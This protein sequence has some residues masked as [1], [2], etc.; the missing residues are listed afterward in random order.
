MI[1]AWNKKYYQP[2]DFVG[3]PTL[4]DYF[5]LYGKS[6]DRAG[7]PLTDTDI[8]FVR[9][10]RNFSAEYNGN[11]SLIDTGTD[12]IGTKAITVMG[13][14]KPYSWGEDAGNGGFIISN[15]KLWVNLSTYFNYIRITRDGSIV[16]S[17]AT[18]SITLNS[19]QFIAITSAG[20]VNIYIANKDT[21]P[22]LSGGADQD[23]GTP[24]AGTT[25]VIIGNHSGATRTFDGLIPI[26]KVVENI[27][28]L[29]QITEFYKY[30]KLF[31]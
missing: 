24:V 11:T 14:I 26:I 17:S 8:G 22:A 25:N 30:S 19:W 23:S 5:S 18:N 15:G 13:W 2:L 28:P 1:I 16:K 27:L 20:V 4:L 12:M 10:G 3:Y 29:A 9:N 7:N 31:L 6:Q 21:P